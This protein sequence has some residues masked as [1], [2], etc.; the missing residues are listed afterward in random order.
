[1]GGALIVGALM[2]GGVD[3]SVETKIIK[4]ARKAV[5]CSNKKPQTRK[6]TELR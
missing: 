3:G 4:A 1:M 2:G 5:I 6:G